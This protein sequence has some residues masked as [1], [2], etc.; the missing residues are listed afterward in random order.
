MGRG[1]A[2]EKCVQ[3]ESN[4]PVRCSRCGMLVTINSGVCSVQGGDANCFCGAQYLAKFWEVS[5]RY[6]TGGRT[7][8]RRTDKKIW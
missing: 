2:Y 5:V 6:L 1:H 7:S 3:V 8:V 4:A